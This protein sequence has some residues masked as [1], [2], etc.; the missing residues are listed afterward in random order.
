MH[1]KN[2][3]GGVFLFYFFTK[4]PSR[5]KKF[6]IEADEKSP[7]HPSP[8]GYTTVHVINNYFNYFILNVSVAIDA[9]DFGD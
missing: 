8:P 6:A 9:N 3:S 4:T 1:E 2:L 5:L 7:N